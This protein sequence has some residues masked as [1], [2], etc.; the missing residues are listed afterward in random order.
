MS[1]SIDIFFVG[2]FYGGNKVA[3]EINNKRYDSLFGHLLNEIR[4]SD[5]SV[6]NLESPIFDEDL[7]SIPKTGPNN[8]GFSNVAKALKYAGFDLCCL[9]NNHIL[10][11]GK[12]GLESTINALLNEELQYVGVGK[13]LIEAREIKY[14]DIKNKRI[15]FINFC[16]NEWSIAEENDFGANPLNLIDVFHQ[17]KEARLNADYVVLIF[18]GGIEHYNL[19]SVEF[20]RVC[21][22]FVDAGAD[23]VICHHTHVVSGFEVHNNKPIFYGLGNFIFQK[24]NKINQLWNTG[25]AVKLKLDKK[26]DFQLFPYFQCNNVIGIEKMNDEELDVFKLKLNEINEVIADDGKLESKLQNYVSSQKVTYDSYF[27]PWSNRILLGLFRRGLF[28][29]V[30]NDKKY[31]ILLNIIRCESHRL[32]LLNFLKNKV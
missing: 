5:I 21:R 27:Q 19:P 14:I 17:I 2:D 28:P 7:K 13:N 25:M 9:A 10:D 11:F 8:K 29:S 15:A 3:Y 30:L 32:V 24:D 18:H 26:I 16:E 1:S 22:F 23:S 6:V 4:N 20:K 31:R 12:A